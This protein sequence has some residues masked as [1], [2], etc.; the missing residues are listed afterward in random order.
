MGEKTDFYEILGVARDADHKT[1]QKAYRGLARQSH[2]DLN[3]GDKGAEERFK[4]ISKAWAILSDTAK[5]KDYDEFGEVSLESGFDADEA[6]R[7]REEF[8]ARFGYGGQSAGRTTGDDFHFGSID[9]LL[10]RMFSR[11]DGGRPERRFQGADLE[12]SLEIDFLE[13]VEGGEKRLSLGRPNADGSISNE[14]VTIRIPPGVD[15]KGRLRVPGKGAPGIGGG[16]PGDLWVSLRVH[17]HPVFERDGRNL[18]LKLP[19]SVREAT[20][21]ATVDVPTL[22]GRAKLTIPAGTDSGTRLRLRTKGVPATRGRSPGDLIVRVEI[23][24][25]KKLDDAGKAAVEALGQLEDPE[26]RKGLFA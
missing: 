10:G 25:P 19:I 9:D 24:V 23:E 18:T 3:P 21:G 4:S 15:S 1:I 17:P 13:A 8:G 6:R 2:P 20:L 12:A 11:E 26:I 5:R 14:V 22:D 7:V 16:P